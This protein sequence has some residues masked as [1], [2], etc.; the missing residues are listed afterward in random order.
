MWMAWRH[1]SCNAQLG[2]TCSNEV[3]LEQWGGILVDRD[4]LYKNRSSRKIDSWRLCLREYDFPKTF[5]LTEISCPR[6]PIFIQL[7]PGLQKLPAFVGLQCENE[8][9]NGKLKWDDGSLYS[10]DP[11]LIPIRVDNISDCMIF[12]S[13]AFSE[14]WC[15][16]SRIVLCQIKCDGK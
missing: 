1:K 9:C 10:F 7:P 15:S 12:Y 8:T 2:R 6:R 14:F 16:K 3:G 11:S 5:S 13:D 4:E